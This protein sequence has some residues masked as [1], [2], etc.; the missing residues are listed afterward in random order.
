MLL[1]LPESLRI[2]PSTNLHVTVRKPSALPFAIPS[3]S[4]KRDVASYSSDQ[5]KVMPVV[6]A[7]GGEEG[8]GGIYLALG[9]NI[10]DRIGHLRRAVEGL[11]DKGVIVLR[12]SRLYESEAMYVEDQDRFVN[13]IIEVSAFRPPQDQI[14][15][16]E[17]Q[18]EAKADILFYRSILLLSQGR[19]G[20]W[21]GQDV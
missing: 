2:H 14:R 10:G 19:E 7:E 9:S 15:M 13:G 6:Q 12:T 5:D 21:E 18:P 8:R 16:S 11:E 3:I 20:G 1:D 4:I 17:C